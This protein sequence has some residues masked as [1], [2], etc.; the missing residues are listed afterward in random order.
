MGQFCSPTEDPDPDFAFGYGSPELN[1]DPIR[2]RNTEI[3][4]TLYSCFVRRY[5]ISEGT[6]PSS[7]VLKLAQVPVVCLSGISVLVPKTFDADPYPR[8]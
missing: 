3:T 4:T 1:P 8:S 7:T 6:V 5:S 2:I